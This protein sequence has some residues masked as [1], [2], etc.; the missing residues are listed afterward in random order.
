MDPSLYVHDCLTDSAVLQDLQNGLGLDETSRAFL[1]VD[2]Q[3][4]VNATSSFSLITMRTTNV[5]V[6]TRPSALSKLKKAVHKRVAGICL[7]TQDRFEWRQAEGE[8][9]VFKE[10]DLTGLSVALRAGNFLTHL[11][12][13]VPVAC[14]RRTFDSLVGAL[15]PKSLLA[16]GL[17]LKPSDA[18]NKWDGAAGALLAFGGLMFLDLSGTDRLHDPCLAG[19]RNVKALKISDVP[20]TSVPDW[21]AELPLESLTISGTKIKGLPESLRALAP[22][23]LELD[24]SRNPIVPAPDVISSF[25]KLRVLRMAATKIT[26]LPPSYGRLS[27]LL[28][29]DLGL[30]HDMDESHY[31]PAFAGFRK[32]QFLQADI[33]PHPLASGEDWPGNV[34][35]AVRHA[36]I[37]RSIKRG[38][39]NVPGVDRVRLEGDVGPVSSSALTTPATCRSL[40]DMPR[41][42]MNEI[43]KVVEPEDLA[44][45]RQTC[46]A[47][48]DA[49]DNMF[50]LFDIAAHIGHN[51]SVRSFLGNATKCCV[52]GCNAPAFD[53][54]RTKDFSVGLGTPRDYNRIL[55]DQDSVD[56]QTTLF[57]PTCGKHKRSPISRQLPILTVCGCDLALFESFNFP[58]TMQAEMLLGSRATVPAFAALA[59][60]GWVASALENRVRCE[61]ALGVDTR[62]ASR[63]VHAMLEQHL[64]D[65]RS[66]D[67][68][69]KKVDKFAAL[70]DKD[71]G[72]FNPLGFMD[73]PYG[74]DPYGDD[75]YDDFYESDEYGGGEYLFKGMYGSECDC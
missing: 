10:A 59:V 31:P 18:K 29:L 61:E 36:D 50:S 68:F 28:L 58:S 47:M 52:R 20:M 43:L 26:T 1:F 27:D 7:G 40:A 32:L 14:T 46:T 11:L 2:L 5:S 74:D 6:S 41:D 49:V 63:S 23:M 64:A 9:P 17:Y 42:V 4:A 34:L 54:G 12:M 38:S 70:C 13:N 62:G 53:G 15:Q 33:D 30:L 3:S 67:S 21:V 51:M 71:P 44:A 72:I 25:T 8:T 19:L 37:Q 22:S 57:T 65:L 66:W 45:V 56:V 75:F 73:D 39:L 48:R 16:L 60:R 55:G 35:A 24:L 69:T